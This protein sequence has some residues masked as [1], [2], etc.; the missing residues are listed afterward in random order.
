MVSSYAQLGQIQAIAPSQ[1]WST[2]IATAAPHQDNLHHS[3]FGSC[4]AESMPSTTPSATTRW[5]SGPLS[6]V[7]GWTHV[8]DGH[9]HVPLPRP[10]Q[11]KVREGVWPDR[12]SRRVDQG[13]RGCWAPNVG[14]GLVAINCQVQAS[15]LSL[16]STLARANSSASCR[17]SSTRLGMCNIPGGVG[18][19]PGHFSPRTHDQASIQT[20]RR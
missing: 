10:G 16:P 18:A 3:A 5:G 20:P 19:C 17:L 12:S 7:K 11:T 6:M 4:M 1:V 14:P 15:R 2:S 9:R 8:G 13:G